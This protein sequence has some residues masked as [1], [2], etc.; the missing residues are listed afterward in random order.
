MN[1]TE[2]SFLEFQLFQLIEDIEIEAIP[3]ALSRVHRI[4]NKLDLIIPVHYKGTVDHT[5]E[6]IAQTEM[7]LI[8]L[9]NK[10]F[11]NN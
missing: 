2:K 11:C 10:L 8:E 7:R 1:K 4:A 5:E 3:D 9:R 6:I